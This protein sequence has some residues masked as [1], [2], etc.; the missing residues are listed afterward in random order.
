MSNEKFSKNP[1]K[2][3][4]IFVD[5]MVPDYV[6]EDHPMFIKFMEKYFEYLERDT[7]FNGE[8]GEFNQISDLSDNIDI[9]RTLDQFI[10]EFEKKYLSSTP[11]APVDFTVAA[12]DKAFL[13]KNVQQTYREKGTESALDFMF[14][15][16]FN[17][18]VEVSY[19]KDQMM[20]VSSSEWYE[21]QW[22]NVASN[23]NY[24]LSQ[25]K[26]EFLNWLG[27]VL[28]TIIDLELQGSPRNSGFA[29]LYAYLEETLPNGFTRWDFSQSGVISV[30][31]VLLIQQGALLS[32]DRLTVPTT[33]SILRAQVV[34]D[35][36]YLEFAD[37]FNLDGYT[38]TQD[39][40]DNINSFKHMLHSPRLL[41]AVNFY[42]N[43]FASSAVGYVGGQDG[44]P[45]AHSNVLPFSFEEYRVIIDYPSSN[46]FDFHSIQSYWP[47]VEYK[48][49]FDYLEHQGYM[50]W[51]FENISKPLNEY[52]WT[53]WS[54]AN[55]GITFDNGHA[56]EYS[57]PVRESLIEFPLFNLSTPD[58]VKNSLFYVST[59]LHEFKIIEWLELDK[60]IGAVTSIYNKKIIG[61]T[62]GAT[63]FVDIEEGTTLSDTTQ[64]LL[65][66]LSGRFLKDE[67]IKEDV[68]TSG[69][70]PLRYKISSEGIMADGHCSINGGKWADRW[71][72]IIGDRRESVHINSQTVVGETS[73]T[74]AFIDVPNVDWTRLDLINA[75][76]NFTQG[77]R[78]YPT[79]ALNYNLN[80]TESFCSSNIHW[81]L[82]SFLTEKECTEAH[83]PE[84]LDAD[85]PHFGENA[86][87]IWFPFITVNS[88]TESIS[89]TTFNEPSSSN[90]NDIEYGFEYGTESKCNIL[91]ESNDDV[92]T[93]IN[94]VVNGSWRDS[95]SFLSSDRMVQDNDYFQDFSYLIKSEV[96]IQKYREVLKKLVHPVGLKLFAE[97]T[98]RSSVDMTVEI[99]GDYVKLQM[100]LFSYLD[101]RMDIMG[102][103]GFEIDLDDLEQ[104]Y[105]VAW[106]K[107]LNV[108]TGL[109]DI[110][111]WGISSVNRWKPDTNLETNTGVCSNISF[112]T[113]STCTVGLG[114]WTI[115]SAPTNGVVGENGNFCGSNII[116][117]DW[118]SITRELIYTTQSDCEAQSLTWYTAKPA[119]C[120]VK[121]SHV[122]YWNVEEYST[123]SKCEFEHNGS[124]EDHYTININPDS[125]V[126]RTIIS[127]TRFFELPNDIIIGKE[128]VR[129]DGTTSAQ[130]NNS[131][132]DNTLLDETS[133]IASG[134][135]SNSNLL[136]IDSCKQNVVCSDPIYT[137]EA[138]CRDKGLCNLYMCSDEISYNQN[139][140]ESA[141]ETWSLGNILDVD[142]TSCLNSS[143]ATPRWF[144][145]QWSN[146]ENEWYSTNAWLNNVLLP[147][148]CSDPLL[149]D[150]SSCINA[151][152]CSD[153]LFN[154]FND[155]VTNAGTWSSFENTWIGG[156]EVIP[157]GT[158]I[159]TGLQE[160]KCVHAGCS[161]PL[162]DTAGGCLLS[163]GTWDKKI[164]YGLHSHECN[165]LGKLPSRNTNEYTISG[166]ERSSY[167]SKIDGRV[168]RNIDK[169]SDEWLSVPNDWKS[170]NDYNR[171]FVPGRIGAFF[172]TTTAVAEKEYTVAWMNKDIVNTIVAYP[173]TTSLEFSRIL[174]VLPIDEFPPSVTELLI[175][176]NLYNTT[177]GSMVSCDIWELIIRKQ[178]GKVLHYLDSFV[179]EADYAPEKSYQFFESNR[180]S[181]RIQNI[182]GKTCDVIDSVHVGVFE[183]AAEEIH[184]HGQEDGFAPLVETVVTKG[185]ELPAMDVGASA[186]HVHYF[187]DQEIKNFQPHGKPVTARGLN[188]AEARALMN[189][190]A[191]EIPH[192]HGANLVC[193]G[194]MTPPLWGD[195]VDSQQ[196][197]RYNGI[198]ECF[199]SIYE[200]EADCVGF[201]GNPM[202][203]M[204]PSCSNMTDPDEA[205]CN[206]NGQSWGYFTLAELPPMKGHVS[207]FVK[208]QLVD[209][210][211][212]R[213]ADPLTREQARQL[214][215]GDITS[216]TLYDNVGYLDDEGHPFEDEYEITIGGTITNIRGEVTSGHYH[217]Y[218]VT[219]DAEW[220][221]NVDWR[222]NPL[223]HGFVYTPITTWLCFNYDPSLPVDET[224]M[225][226]MDFTGQ[227][228]PQN[229][230]LDV[231]DSYVGGFLN[232]PDITLQHNQVWAE[233]LNPNVDFVE[234][235]SSNHIAQVPGVGS[236][237]D[238]IGVQNLGSDTDIATIDA[239]PTDTQSDTIAIVDMSGYIKL[240]N[241]NTGVKT[242]F[243][244]L[245]SLQH[246]IGIGP[247]G[248]Y[249]ERGTIGLTFHPNYNVNGKFYV[250][251]MIEQGG[252]TG[253][254]G[255]PLSTSVI[256]EFTADANRLECTDLTT[257]RN[258]FTIPQPDMNHNGGQLRFGSD[259]FLYIGLGDGGN[260]GDRSSLTGHGGH[261]DYGNAQ[262][263]TNLL[264]SILRVDV[265][266][267]TVNNMPY[268]IPADNP[269]IGVYYKEGQVEQELYRPEIYAFGMRNPWRFSF[270][271]NDKLW[272]ADVGQ[273]NFE[274]IN[275]IEKGGNYG[276]RVMEAYHQ[277]ETEQPII[278]Q[279]AIDLGFGSTFDYLSSLKSP[280]H[281]YSHGIGISILG[282]FVY[283][284]SIPELQGK[285]IFGDWS[286]T[287]EG[288]NG[289]LYT[290]TENFDG[291]SAHFNVLPNAINGSSH[292]HTIDLTGAEVSYLKENPG[293]PIVCI[294]SDNVHSEFYVHTFT[295]IWSSQNQEF[296]ILG[297]TNPEGHDVLE[298]VSYGSDLAYDRT[299]LSIWDPL[300][301]VVDLTTLGESIL[302]FGE[303]SSGE[304]IF[305]TRAGIDTFQGSG[306]NNTS[307]YKITDSYSSVDIPNANIQIP[308]SETGHIHGYEVTYD[309]ENFFQTVE[310]SDIEMREWDAYWPEW[311]WN[312]PAS[313]IHS[314]NTAWSGILDTDMLLGSSAG[315][316]YDEELET[317]QPYDIGADTPWAPPVDDETSYTY[318]ETAPKISI[319][320]ANEYGEN[321]HIHYF[322]SS[323]LDTFGEAVGT[324]AT[325]ITRLQAEGLANGEFS[326]V[327]IYSSV[328]NSG[329][330]LHYHKYKILWN[331]STQQ[332]L[333]QDAGEFHDEL[334]IG[335]YSIIDEVQKNHEH[336]LTVDGITTNLGWNGTPLFTAP[337]VTLGW[338][339]DWDNLEGDESDHL[340]SFN[341]TILDTIGIHA[342]RI[343]A[344]LT[345]EQTTDLINGDLTEVIIY[346]SIANG[347][348]YHAIKVTYDDTN[349]AFIAEDT[350]QWLSEDG[351]QFVSVTPRHH[352]HSTAISNYLS[353]DGF[354]QELNVN[355]MPIFASPGYP[356]PGGTHPHFHNGTVVGPFAWNDKIDYADGLTVQN[357]MDLINGHVESVIIYDSIEGAHFH[358]YTIKY[359]ATDNVFY[360]TGSVTWIRGGIEDSYQDHLK[361]YVSDVL[362]PSEGLHW[363]NLTVE[364]NPDNNQ[365]PQQSG[366][367]VYVTRVVTTPEVLTSD[368]QTSIT[369]NSVELNPII[370]TLVDLPEVGDTTEITKFLDNVTTSTIITTTVVTTVT[371]ETYYSDGE[372]ITIIG[373]PQTTSE[374]SSSSSTAQIEDMTERQTRV[375][376]ILQANNSPIIWI[377]GTFIDG[378]GTHDHLLFN[379]CELDTVGPFSGRMCE[380]ISL[381][382]SNDLINAQDVNY[383][384]IFYD[385][386]NGAASHYHG[387][388]LRFNPYIGADGAFVVESIN[389]YDQI[390]GTGT[391]VHKFLLTGGFHDHDYWISVTEYLQL[392]TGTNITTVQRDDIHRSLYTHDVTISYSSGQYNLLNQT[393][394]LDG[395]TLISYA[396]SQ[397]SGGQW[398]ISTQGQG[399]GDHIHTTIVDETNVWPVGI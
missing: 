187:N 224:I 75:S 126:D 183:H 146:E 60:L 38:D 398:T 114:T 12:T 373:N 297:Q 277:F 360:C 228:W 4:S 357:A 280:I 341:G 372:V 134:S 88:K 63:A 200:N 340:H 211:R 283:R 169:V 234:L 130:Y 199:N 35:H 179:S 98:L 36:I 46:D 226:G 232:N 213:Y 393:N 326:E 2:Y 388:V 339:H 24:V 168:K 257:E 313:H 15:R 336:T 305:T 190:E 214:I 97:F 310:V 30:D 306:V 51:V 117:N 148:V 390:P 13:T 137:D 355:N 78:I 207:Y 55:N 307:L 43:Y 3:L 308:S 284:G 263:P 380:P 352:A 298:F 87:L 271:G 41:D 175:Q 262:N 123:Q 140:C 394:N 288:K 8:V 92:N 174:Q 396:G 317:W 57:L 222:G 282:G 323:T 85:S 248:A 258:L 52:F 351:V 99:P 107:R 294:Q 347:D 81:P 237:G 319:L 364:W 246:V 161:D 219:Y 239:F 128:Q 96:P 84:Y 11:R 184:S 324:L 303:T 281:E 182:Y 295:I 59:H 289:H 236:A 266:E 302:T 249:D 42:I 240:V 1:A 356:Y 334:G 152:V 7:D 45:T 261:G 194:I 389:Q 141:G 83:H 135:C 167:I 101:V 242:A 343:S 243:M 269:F 311:S 247:F 58:Y 229:V 287:W 197:P 95:S 392:V 163:N 203:W 250:Y 330:S 386:P 278:D 264:G 112:T 367:A 181:N 378:E 143:M 196:D 66:E 17:T 32:N 397:A 379:G 363:H 321:T 67:F 377:Q 173:E 144:I 33:D 110:H 244:D 272:C 20:K 337:D 304:I 293:S 121:S 172:S 109:V 268:T 104:A 136:D 259:G 189:R 165:A 131:C 374:Q 348:H 157:A 82:G 365:V 127:P 275:I 300:T 279:M 108:N 76:G 350:E 14:R 119:H 44:T 385:S 338:A 118:T 54:D 209:R 354:N 309:D 6:R 286:T 274:E 217:E 361:Y 349:L 22:I 103:D 260:A 27:E 166:K 61:E 26:F 125:D 276:W 65:T 16:D 139:T 56:S 387:Y 79:N 333:A 158:R 342:G 345:D 265:T 212:N 164:T 251:Y 185:L 34:V 31:D 18:E 47:K 381:A 177:N 198:G 113:E 89:T 312:D 391:T 50:N 160:S 270:D 40:S 301:E 256:S 9:D 90:Y 290:L 201:F 285:Y 318:I 77:E 116:N 102:D 94:W 150:E 10:P 124:K 37:I 218:T 171:K 105:E 273:D 170:S 178:M 370:E 120:Y 221:D 368:P 399:L 329:T 395:H 375:N 331:P 69:N 5:R 147:E 153:G 252:G 62:S 49:K 115:T 332:F 29:G 362:N 267:D 206:A 202:F 299:P 245:S 159:V 186:F 344:P 162:L 383:G 80:P 210:Q 253:S 193:G 151:G 384:T 106:L 195:W 74:T 216:V 25:S 176:D 238:L 314:V 296:I 191:F 358:D 70:V 359:N 327:Y 91:K 316:Y 122:E 320:G 68:G 315:W 254:F 73:G 366:G 145:N 156:D 223:T 231:P 353:I 215:D 376:G 138:T 21:P 48:L 86:G 19:P 235:Y 132:S 241:E 220:K 64:L 180:E 346:S 111:E 335:E 23:P 28:S 72:H 225:G 322:D 208:G 71:I 188:H 129:L 100:F 142:E 93:T 205:T 192:M 133:C 382:M 291:N 255:Y 204:S 53:Q 325:P 233:D 227:P 149:S 230:F 39:E 369:S 154:N 328:S 371:T 292:S 155:C